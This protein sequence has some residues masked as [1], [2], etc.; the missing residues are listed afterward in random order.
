MPGMPGMC[1][2]GMRDT[3]PTWVSHAPVNSSQILPLPLLHLLLHL[4][5]LGG[6]EGP[7]AAL[8]GRPAQFVLHL[9]KALVQ[10]QVVAH[11]ILPPIRGC[12]QRARRG[13]WEKGK[14]GLECGVSKLWSAQVP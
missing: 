11:G 2:T 4:V 5:D 8:A 9:L 14:K 3:S 10:G 7:Q 12:L 13:S 6:V 1:G